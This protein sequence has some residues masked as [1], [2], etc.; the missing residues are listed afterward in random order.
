MAVPAESYTDSSLIC[1]HG[2]KDSDQGRYHNITPELNKLIPIVHLFNHEDLS[3]QEYFFA[4][5]MIGLWAALRAQIASQFI[6]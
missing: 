4:I 3:P 5:L 2:H 1:F 6:G